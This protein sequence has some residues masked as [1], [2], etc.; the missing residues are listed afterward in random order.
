MYDIF[1]SSMKAH[2]RST[3]SACCTA[4][5]F[6]DATTSI[7]PPNAPS[8]SKVARNFLP[9]SSRLTHAMNRE[10]IVASGAPTG[11]KVPGVCDSHLAANPACRLDL[12]S[13]LSTTPERTAMPIVP[14]P[15]THSST[16]GQ[17]RY[18]K[19]NLT[20][21]VYIPWCSKEEKRLGWLHFTSMILSNF[22]FS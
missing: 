19:P 5:R 15:R 20:R 9:L 18:S 1:L 21:K 17:D 12:A 4:W 22:L 13:R 8:P 6:L 7:E 10:G 3:T 2:E 16:E 11:V 14:H